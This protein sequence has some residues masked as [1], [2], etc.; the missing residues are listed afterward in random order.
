MKDMT[1]KQVNEDLNLKIDDTRTIISIVAYNGRS[2]SISLS[3]GDLR[4]VNNWLQQR[5]RELV[6]A[7][8]LEVE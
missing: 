8:F 7:G 2:C 4:V 5:E 3:P 1:F 6:D